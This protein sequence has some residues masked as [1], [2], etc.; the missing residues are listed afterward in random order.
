[1]ERKCCECG[2][3]IKACMGFTIAGDFLLAVEKKIPWK[4]VKELCGRCGLQKLITGSCEIEPA[5]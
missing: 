4:E 3:P 5:K 2:R 1:M